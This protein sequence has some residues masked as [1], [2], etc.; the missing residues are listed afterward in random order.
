MMQAK[1]RSVRENSFQL[2]RRGPVFTLMILGTNNLDDH[3]DG[4]VDVECSYVALKPLLDMLGDE[5][6]SFKKEQ[7]ERG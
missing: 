7:E 3:I 4:E 5:L 6:E 1:I 2:K